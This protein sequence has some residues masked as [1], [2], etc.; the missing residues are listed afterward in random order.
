[1]DD[2][3]EF[4]VKN[5]EGIDIL[6]LDDDDDDDV[7]DDDEEEGFCFEE[8][9]EANDEES[10]KGERDDD[11]EGEGFE[12]IEG[13]LWIKRVEEVIENIEGFPEITLE[14]ELAV[15]PFLEELE[16]DEDV[17]ED[18]DEGE[19]DFGVVWILAC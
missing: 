9:K 14:I 12:V 16:F 13:P 18:E 5:E 3:D 1:M 15:V 19:F 4:E 6:G 10:E 11:E 2:G 7:E 17:E 8:E